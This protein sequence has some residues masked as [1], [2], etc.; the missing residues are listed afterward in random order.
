M[1]SL[2]GLFASGA[3]L[4]VATHAYGVAW[5][6]NDVYT[7]TSYTASSERQQLN[8]YGGEIAFNNTGSYGFVR[9]VIRIDS[10]AGIDV[11]FVT[12][13][14]ATPRPI[15]FAKDVF[16]P[17]GGQLVVSESV[18]FGTFHATYNPVISLH[19][20]HKS[21]PP[22]S[23]QYVACLLPTKLPGTKAPWRNTYPL[24]P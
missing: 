18:R 17:G 16:N 4:L 21:V 11:T 2:K 23:T 10:P 9:N 20:T 19:R 3:A 5:V 13:N 22:Q 12:T 14:S 24:F 1:A 6:T 8:M 7:V 15:D